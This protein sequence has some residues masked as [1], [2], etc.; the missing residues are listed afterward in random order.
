MKNPEKILV[1]RN[2][3]LGDFMLAYPAFNVIK[4]LFPSSKIYALVP[5]YTK[6]MAE[7]C[8]WI[9]EIIIDN[10]TNGFHGLIKLC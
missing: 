7:L 3:R 9:D 5:E 8:E 6:P 10:V 2:D 4:K 1:V